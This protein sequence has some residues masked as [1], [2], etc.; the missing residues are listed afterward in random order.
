MADWRS[1]RFLESS[2]V[3]RGAVC[4]FDVVCLIYRHLFDL[5][6]FHSRLTA[7]VERMKMGIKA[8]VSRF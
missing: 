6:S 3:A 1:A 5:H 4:T 2:W 7:I 8:K